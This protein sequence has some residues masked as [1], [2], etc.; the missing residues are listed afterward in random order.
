MAIVPM[1]DGPKVSPTVQQADNISLIAPKENQAENAALADYGKAASYL[2]KAVDNA[3]ERFSKAKADAAFND[4][5]IATDDILRG[6]NGALLKQG[7]E[8]ISGDKSFVDDYMGQI[9]KVVADSAQGLDPYQKRILQR[10]VGNFMA[11]RH[12]E[13]TRH[14]IKEAQ[15]FEVTVNKTKAEIAGRNI[16]IDPANIESVKRNRQDIAEAIIAMNP[17]APKE[18]LDKAIDDAVSK[19]LV[20]GIESFIANGDP[21]RAQALFAH[22]KG[23]GITA[24]DALS[25]Q[26]KIR[27][28]LIKKQKEAQTQNALATTRMSVTPRGIA[29]TTLTTPELPQFDG[30]KFDKA[31]EQVTNVGR[32]EWIAYTY[33]LG[34]QKSQD[35]IDAWAKEGDALKKKLDDAKAKAVENPKSEEAKRAVDTAG[36]ALNAFQTR[37]P[38]EGKLSDAQMTALNAYNNKLQ[39]ANAG[40][41]ETIREQVLSVNPWIGKSELDKSVNALFEERQ[42]QAQ[43]LKMQAT[44]QASNV[45]N[46]LNNGVRFDD[47]P[48]NEKDRL[49]DWQKEGLKE[50]DSRR[51]MGSKFSTDTNTYCKYRYDNKA[52]EALDWADLYGYAGVLRPKDLNTLIRRKQDIEAGKLT[53]DDPT[54]VEG[55]VDD[56]LK[57]FGY[58]PKN[59]GDKELYNRMKLVITE[60]VEDKYRDLA[61]EQWK[62]LDVQAEVT[63]FVGQKFSAPGFL[64]GRNTKTVGDLIRDKSAMGNDN[65]KRGDKNL[66]DLLDAALKVTGYPDP[67]Q[68]DRAEYV[69][70]FLLNQ[71]KSLPGES[72]LADAIGATELA[73]IKNAYKA[74]HNGTEPDE[75][76][77]VRAALSARLFE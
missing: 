62:S 59:S 24:F 21:G 1:P 25:L 43:V 12:A 35:I 73:R 52:L 45:F 27:D 72:A 29:A 11:N 64:W 69:L 51:A 46:K 5:Q 57:R 47:I 9:K 71:N 49:T 26:P 68:V 48:D 28:A 23:K 76:T 54:G 4:I 70:D 55:A 61:P 38:F 42:R 77:I 33:L 22:Y 20:T 17:G 14:Q 30:K 36:A 32:P 16:A 44:Q 40:D 2:S 3:Y 50:F 67:K 19:S 58:Y 13:L 75:H 37:N 7:S 8:C 31:A 39:L 63:K 53:A 41:K 6:Q 66:N 74:V 34:E 18:A 65:P 10:R 56:V 60:H 15:A